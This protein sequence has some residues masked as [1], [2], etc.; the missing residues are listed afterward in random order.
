MATEARDIKKT[1]LKA[2]RGHMPEEKQA[3]WKNVQN[4]LFMDELQE[5]AI[6]LF[7]G[8]V[9][10]L[11]EGKF[12]ADVMILTEEGLKKDERELLR[13]IL[14]SIDIPESNV[15]QTTFLKG[16]H[17]GR[18]NPEED[19]EHLLYLFEKEVEI[20]QPII[21]IAFG[22]GKI[23]RFTTVEGARML[24]T[25]SLSSMLEGEDSQKAKNESWSSMQELMR[26][27]DE[28]IEEGE[29]S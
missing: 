27:Y 29:S 7:G 24:A 18:Y 11:G 22:I 8:R 26:Y 3:A 2:M 4:Y 23:G 13:N 10:E 1:V 14:R 6:Q 28:V 12:N 20:I 16:V 9:V 17:H 15:Y 19:N 25:Y 5:E 21:V